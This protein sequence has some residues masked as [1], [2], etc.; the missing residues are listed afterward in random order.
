MRRG[1]G[2]FGRARAPV[3]FSRVAASCFAPV[4]GWLNRVSRGRWG[5]GQTLG[6]PAL[7]LV[8]TGRSS[9][10]LRRSPLLYVPWHGSFAVVGSN[11]GKPRHPG[12]TAN[13]LACP[14]AT[15]VVRGREVPVRARLVEEAERAEIWSAFVALARSYR[16]YEQR[17]SRSL[18]LFL[19]EP[20]NHPGPSQA[21][22]GVARDVKARGAASP[23]SGR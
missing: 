8:T 22:L 15:V 2:W 19:L 13:L 16:A 10:V 21:D 11:F 17:C 6:T 18:R 4:D 12:W 20:V 5:F 9:G 7:L 1:L 3:W 23:D 14:E